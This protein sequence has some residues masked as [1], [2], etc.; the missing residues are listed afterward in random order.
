MKAYRFRILTEAN[1][2]FL[3]EIDVLA[4]QTFEDFHKAIVETTKLKGNELASF[5]I[6]DHAW[7][8]K[9]EIA[10]MDMNF[11]ENSTVSIMHNTKLN[12]AIFDPHQKLIYVY[13]YLNMYTFEIELVKI[14]DEDSK[15]LY[16]RVLKSFS[17]LQ[18]SMSPIPPAPMA[19]DDEGTEMLYSEEELDDINSYSDENDEGEEPG[20]GN[21]DEFIEEGE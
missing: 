11:D 9:S 4:S 13:D 14:Q 16:P 3:R 19:D 6:C 10:L 21:I 12:A 17:D 20:I 18:M 15:I 5:Y 2:E 7:R 8:K 1:E